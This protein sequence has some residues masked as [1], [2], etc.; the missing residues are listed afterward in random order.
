MKP[1]IIENAPANIEVRFD[2]HPLQLP[3]VIR[4]KHNDY[5]EQ[6]I[7]DNP[8]LRNGEVFTMI[9]I[10][11]TPKSLVITVAKTDYKHY[12]YTLRHENSA[13]P[14]KV[15]Y[16][17]AAVITNDNQIVIGRMNGKTST[18]GRL[19]AGD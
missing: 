15:I 5:W 18:P 10:A 16:T 1:I 3:A 19:R 12:L 4:S 14:C 11:S 17:C 6:Q 9:D 2:C 7:K 8:S 13:N